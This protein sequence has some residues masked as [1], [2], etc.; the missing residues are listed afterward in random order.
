VTAGIYTAVVPG[1]NTV[2]RLFAD[3]ESVVTYPSA[4]V[5]AATAVDFI[6]ATS[7]APAATTSA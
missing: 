4:V 7:R 3:D 2:A 1:C 5:A 6:R